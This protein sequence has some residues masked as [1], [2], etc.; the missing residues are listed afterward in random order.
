M[1][2][3]LSLIQVK[4][5]AQSSDK[6]SDP[7]L[8]KVLI[9]NWK[10]DAA[11]TE[12]Y[13]KAQK[14][15]ESVIK[16]AKE[17]CEAGIMLNFLSDTELEMG[18]GG[19]TRKTECKFGEVKKVKNQM[20]MDVSMGPGKIVIAMMDKNTLLITPKFSPDDSDPPLVFARQK[21]GAKDSKGTEK[22]SDKGKSDK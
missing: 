6:K 9:G 5:D 4:A 16:K 17:F 20:T 10:A 14:T 3:C 11:K 22:K 18:Q 12:K 19:R 8:K 1:L 13:M 7:D 2:L 15:E 21:K